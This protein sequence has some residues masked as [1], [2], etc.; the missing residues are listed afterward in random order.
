MM[1]GMT[2]FKMIQ[3]LQMFPI[4][5][6]VVQVEITSKQDEI[7]IEESKDVVAEEV[8]SSKTSSLVEEKES[9]SKESIKPTE[10]RVETVLAEASI[11][12]P[13]LLREAVL[14]DSFAS[15]SGTYN[16]PDPEGE[17][18]GRVQVSINV[19]CYGR[20]VINCMNRWGYDHT[21]LMTC[22]PSK[23]DKFAEEPFVPEL[24]NVLLRIFQSKQK[25]AQL[26]RKCL[27]EESRKRK[28]RWY[29][30]ARECLPA[31]PIPESTSMEELEKQE[32][33]RELAWRKLKQ[34]CRQLKTQKPRKNSLYDRLEEV[35]IPVEGEDKIQTGIAILDVDN[36]FKK[37]ANKSIVTNSSSGSKRRRSTNTSG[38]SSQN[39]ASKKV[40]IVS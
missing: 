39:R 25:S 3:T 28:C 15:D 27:E 38:R 35:K 7:P 6:R 36:P 31:C 23:E 22:D 10:E 20:A 21:T 26:L 11:T 8:S 1:F 16:L 4:K 9:V 32:L 33:G 34:I 40:S 17:F 29:E 24:D 14:K 30:L 19:K 5:V 13:E 12:I 18:V 37:E 2:G